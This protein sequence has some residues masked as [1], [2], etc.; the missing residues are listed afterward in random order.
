MPAIVTDGLRT[1]LA[2]QFFDQFVNATSRY[3]V[4]IGRSEVWDS[5][6]TVPTPTNTPTTVSGAR[7]QMQSIKK[8]Q[9]VS[10]V[11]PRYNW[12]SG[13]IY[14]QYDNTTSGY[15]TQPYYVMNENNNVYICLETG[16]N[17]NGVAVPSI[18]EPTLANNHSFRLGDG[19]VW[20]F[21][22]TVSAER[23]NN[24]MSSNY[25][26][27]KRQ[28]ATDSNSTGIQLKQEEIQDTAIPGAVTSVI[29]TS[30]GSGYTSNP[31]VTI[32]GTGS[33]AKAHARIDSA[34]GTLA[35][36]KMNDSATTQALGSGYT[37]AQVKLTG[38]GAL[39][40]QAT[41]RPVLGPDSGIG[42]DCRVDLKSGSIM[43]HSRIEGTDSNFIVGQ[44]FRQVTLVKDIKDDQGIVYTQTTGSTLKKMTLNTI[45]TAFTRDKKIR[46]TTTLAEA[47]IDDIDSN[48][49]YYHQTDSTGFTAFQ[50]GEALTE[51][52]G[53][54]TV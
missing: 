19:Y 24:F 36:I 49:I 27:V 7:H 43:F 50:D 9:A 15:P 22:F 17:N 5:S 39:A 51:A 53:A 14:S 16:R 47:Y 3:Y 54:G 26:P 52:N 6:D 20:K 12:S 2:R 31:T 33:G 18:V 34:T 38:G 40:T 44:D 8:V 11:V 35:W 23:A 1:L 10:L 37:V 45:V 13:T 42:A 25:M 4:S 28:D 48:E 29:I 30:V 32:T 46:G 21:L 41:A